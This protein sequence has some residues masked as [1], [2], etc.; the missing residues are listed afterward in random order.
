ML[1]L[2]QALYSI[3]VVLDTPEKQWTSEQWNVFVE[4]DVTR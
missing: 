3:L 2:Q 4:C 1:L